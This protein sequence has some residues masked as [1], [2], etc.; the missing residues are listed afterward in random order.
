[1]MNPVSKLRFLLCVF[2]L[3]LLLSSLSPPGIQAQSSQPVIQQLFA[4]GCDSKTN[5]CANGENPN[6]LMQ[7]ADG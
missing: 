1:M 6:W 2:S 5:V 7:S 4:F 3:V